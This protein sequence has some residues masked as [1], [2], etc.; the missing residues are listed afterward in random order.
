MLR[1][2]SAGIGSEGAQGA[3]TSLEY[4]EGWGRD[5]IGCNVESGEPAEESRGCVCVQL[6]DGASGLETRAPGMQAQGTGPVVPLP[7]PVYLFGELWALQWR[8]LKDWWRTSVHYSLF[9]VFCR[10]V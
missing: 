4:G 8:V 3:F 2:G 5:G 9:S 6:E 10:W 1:M 7:I